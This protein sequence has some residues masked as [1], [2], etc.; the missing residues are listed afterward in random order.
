MINYE[1][2]ISNFD[3]KT[4]LYNWLRKVEEALKHASATNF[5]VN[6][7]G[8]ATL[9][10]SIAFADGT[11]LE[12]GD[13]VL[14]QG[15]SV[16]GARIA[17]GVLQLH[18]TNGSWLTAGNLGAVSGFSIDA[19]QHLI[20]TYQD[21]TSEDL[22][23]I[24]NGNVSISGNLSATGTIS[25]PT[26]T[27]T[28]VNTT[29]VGATYVQ[30]ISLKA[31]DN[32]QLFEKIVDANLK[33]RFVEGNGTINALTGFTSCF[34]KWS[35]SGSHLM[36]V[37]AGS[38]AN[39]T[40]IPSV[41]DIALFDL[42]SWIYNKIYPVWSAYLEDKVITCRATNWSSQDVDM[43]LLKDAGLMKIRLLGAPT[44]LT[45]LRSFRVQFDL[46]IDNE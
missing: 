29:N 10:F 31:T 45:A 21:G 13:I 32:A 16:D 35:L 1:T 44:T 28:D 7:K 40:E 6:K 27:A 36:F 3:D 19:N 24:F 15:E 23:A 42:P 37:L 22:G 25:A 11:T 26:I 39:G 17:S 14:Q 34:C 46:I 38:F 33:N 8:N 9:S 4:T 41:H 18:L 43:A 30:T 5:V 2:I 12:S 20:V